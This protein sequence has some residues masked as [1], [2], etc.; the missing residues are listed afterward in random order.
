M[1]TDSDCFEIFRKIKT[2]DRATNFR[3]R[4]VSVAIFRTCELR[5]HTV[6]TER[7]IFGVNVSMLVLTV[8]K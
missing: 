1:K 6:A 5:G 3:E 8:Q 7:E 4:N 2:G